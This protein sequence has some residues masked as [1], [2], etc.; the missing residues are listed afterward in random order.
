[1]LSV[2]NWTGSVDRRKRISIKINV[3]LFRGVADKRDQKEME[4]NGTD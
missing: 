3:Y 4:E 2:V 1:M